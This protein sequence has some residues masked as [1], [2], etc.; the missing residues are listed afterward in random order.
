MTDEEYQ[1][2]VSGYGG[3]SVS[4]PR[5]VWIIEIV[6]GRDKESSQYIKTFDTVFRLRHKNSGCYLYSHPVKLPDWGFNQQEVTCGTDVLKA[7]TL[8][9]IEKNMN[10][11]CKYDKI[12]IIYNLIIITII[13]IICY[14]C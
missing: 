4:D 9:A 12:T 10:D 3:P 2:E 13:I 5:D 11:S 8:W 14:Y 7:N 6:K 1:N